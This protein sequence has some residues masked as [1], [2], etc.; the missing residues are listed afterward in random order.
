MGAGVGDHETFENIVEDGLNKNLPSDFQYKKIEILNMGISG[1][2]LVNHVGVCKE[3]IARFT[4]DGIIYMA[5]GNEQKR[6]IKSFYKAM[7]LRNIDNYPFLDSLKTK[8]DLQRVHKR[9]ANRVLSPYKDELWFWAMNEIATMC[10]SNEV[11]YTWVYFPGLSGSDRDEFDELSDRVVDLG[12]N[13][14]D[15]SEVFSGTDK[16]EYIIANDDTHPNALG[17]QRIADYLE[18]KL[19]QIIT[20]AN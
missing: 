18:P 17:H 5:H 15:L 1:Q 12:Y 10:R 9:D 8:L 20:G 11:D 2:H 14:I 16:R 19:R 7:I 13:L 4:P 6:S 3:A